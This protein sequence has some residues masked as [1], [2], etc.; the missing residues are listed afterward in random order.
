MTRS[1]PSFFINPEVQPTGTAGDTVAATS[2]LAFQARAGHPGDD[3]DVLMC[4]QIVLGRNPENSFVIEEAK[5]QSIA[6]MMCAFLHSREFAGA[7]LARMREG[8]RLPH[9]DLSSAPSAQQITWLA[10]QL[11]LDEAQQ[12]QVRGVRTW[13]ALVGF[14][15]QLS[16]SRLRPV[17][18]PLEAPLPASLVP[19]SLVP[20]PAATSGSRDGGVGAPTCAASQTIAALHRRLERIEGLL[21]EMEKRLAS[22]DEA[23]PS[24]EPSNRYKGRRA[25][26]VGADRDGADRDFAP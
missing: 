25:D 7:V 1:Q 3:Y 20:G 6:T 15:S 14:L 17:E 12:A 19:G 8:G 22:R 23:A 10:A 24:P 16:I 9:A 2:P 26:R 11:V 18:A 4:Y 21:L 13:E 5:T